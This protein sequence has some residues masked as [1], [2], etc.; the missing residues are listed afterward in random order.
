L[1]VVRMTSAESAPN[2]RVRMSRT[3]SRAWIVWAWRPVWYQTLPTY[4]IHGSESVV[5]ILDNEPPG[6][7][8]VDVTAVDN[9]ASETRSDSA[10][11][12]FSRSMS[13]LT[14]N[15]VI[16]YT[17]SGD[18]SNGVDYG[19]LPGVVT[20]PA[21]EEFALVFVHAVND[22]FVEGNEITG[23]LDWSEA[24]PGDALYDL[25][26]LTLGHEEHVGDVVA[27]Y[28]GDVDLK[29]VRGWWS[30]RCLRGIRWLTEHGFDPYLPGCEIDVLRSRM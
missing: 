20:I 14:N 1:A 27:G 2:A 5:Q 28:G 17:V 29:V 3:C 24:G 16:H 21:G 30:L 19:F 22:L 11:L 4:V 25:A 8:M 6:R 18:A 10:T 7:P 13:T 15:L 23:V 9:A 26:T 12:M